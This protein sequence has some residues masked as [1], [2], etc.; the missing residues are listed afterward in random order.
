V[1]FGEDRIEKGSRAMI[2]GG[3]APDIPMGSLAFETIA[4]LCGRTVGQRRVARL[5]RLPEAQSL[6]R[7]RDVLG[8]DPGMNLTARVRLAKGSAERRA[9]SVVSGPSANRWDSNCPDAG[10]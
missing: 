6:V 7:D 8:P 10:W 5:R 1:G 2:G 4:G 9:S 3:V